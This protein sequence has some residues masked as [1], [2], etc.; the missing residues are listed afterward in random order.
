V[1]R[2]IATLARQSHL[3][4]LLSFSIRSGHNSDNP[5]GA[6]GIDTSSVD[7]VLSSTAQQ[8]EELDGGYYDDEDD[9]WYQEREGDEDVDVLEIKEEDRSIIPRASVEDVE[10]AIG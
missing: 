1:E 6:E 9:P 3:P 10:M 8:E 4:T 7:A 2:G 5:G